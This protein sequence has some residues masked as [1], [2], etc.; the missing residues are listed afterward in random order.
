MPQRVSDRLSRSAP[1]V[2]MLLV[3]L[4]FGANLMAGSGSD[5]PALALPTALAYLALAFL[6]YPGRVPSRV[7]RTTLA[8]AITL[9]S[10]LV[11]A[12]RF[13]GLLGGS[14]DAALQAAELSQLGLNGHVS[15]KSLIFIATCALAVLSA[16]QNRLV[17]A[18]FVTALLAM[19][20]V[21]VVDLA[22]AG[23]LWD[24]DLSLW[25]TLCG[26]ILTLSAAL[27]L[28]DRSLFSPLFLPGPAGRALRLMAGGALVLP[29]GAGWIYAT[30]LAPDADEAA[31][32]G[33][34][35]GGLGWG[36]FQITFILGIFIARELRRVQTMSRQDA[37]TG[38]LNRKGFEVAMA[39]LKADVAGLMLCDLD[40]FK[41]ADYR[42]GHR[43][44]DAL[45]RDVA[46][47]IEGEIGKAGEQARGAHVARL[48]GD[49][50]MI[51][52]PNLTEPALSALAERIHRA[53]ATMPPVT[54]DDQVY[55]PALLI[56]CVLYVPAT[57]A[58]ESSLRDAD[59]ALHWVKQNDVAIRRAEEETGAGPAGTQE[60]G[61]TERAQASVVSGVG[62][63]GTTV[64][65]GG[66]IPPRVARGIVRAPEVC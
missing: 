63:P 46:A 21:A 58:L 36:M 30:L 39:G 29:M 2:V 8:A 49:E 43:E 9:G 16:R 12:D 15:T 50:F 42:F 13:T 64:D 34:L 35:F 57:M 6:S 4:G 10:G 23:A 31:L 41:T 66:A 25:S 5:R 47:V 1:I 37:L 48:G 19:T 14:A 65:Q 33:L 22:M 32:I 24:G 11:L 27:R 28:R 60:A 44:R 56:G 3:T 61:R 20:N 51:A 40:R 18:L 38:L 53:V 62:A 54:A 45:L 59:D 26:F 7:L 17:S 55:Q 52:V